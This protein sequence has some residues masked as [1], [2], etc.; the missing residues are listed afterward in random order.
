MLDD[1]KQMPIPRCGIE[2]IHKPYKSI[3]KRYRDEN[4]SLHIKQHN[5]I[6]EIG[7]SKQGWIKALKFYFDLLTDKD[8]REIR[9]ITFDYDNVRPYGEKLMTFGGRASGYESMKNM[10]TKIDKVIKSRSGKLLPID[11]IDISNI[12]A[13]NVVVGGTRRS[14][15]IALIDANDKKSIQAKN[16]LYTQVDGKWIENKEILHRRMSNNTIVYKEKPTREQL[17]WNL[18]QMRYS[19]EPAFMNLKEALRRNPNAKG[20]N[21]CAEIILDDRGTCNLSV[22]NLMGF[23]NEDGTY[24]KADLLEAQALSARLCYRMTCV[25]L[26]MHEWAKTQTRDRL[27]GCDITGTQD[28]INATQISRDEFNSLCRELRNEARET[29]K[30]IAEENGLNESLLVTAGKP[31]GSLA[32][33][34]TVSA[35]IHFSHSP[36][37]IRRVRISTNDPL[38]KVIEDLGYPINPEV[39]QEMETADTKVVEFPVKAPEGKTKYDVSAIEQ[40][41]IYKDM[42]ENY[43]EM[44]QS[45]TVTVR[46]DEW[47]QVEEWLWENW[48]SMV[49]VSF[50]PLDDSYYP[51]LPYEAC[52][53]EEYEKR[54]MEMKP[55]N[56]EL[57]QKYEKE[58]SEEDLE[59][60]TECSS[61]ACGVR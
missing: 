5:A 30:R 48:D 26:E 24:N 20:L 6:I 52:T 7:D 54:T 8:Y 38:C 4:T 53:K 42:M 36:Y 23:V 40:L 50:L 15:E 31:N 56:P 51:L 22:V 46:N 39:G 12:I 13:E 1:V 29:M 33:L 43:I 3:R 44:N 18:E 21:P 58:E 2:V 61:G 16:N 57:I 14:A 55:F 27:L 10:V 25:E 9:T 37:Y 19:G 47:E 41:E 32:L 59:A 34:P 45:I 60:D 49:A 35:G 11:C 17:H 28:F